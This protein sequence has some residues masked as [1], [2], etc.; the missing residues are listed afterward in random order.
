MERAVEV[1]AIGG[2]G[3][4]LAALLAFLA[5]LMWQGTRRSWRQW[6]RWGDREYQWTFWGYVFLDVFLAGFVVIG[7]VG[8]VVDLLRRL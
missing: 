7:L 3:V 6:Q 2:L 8:L 4:L 1:W 5:F